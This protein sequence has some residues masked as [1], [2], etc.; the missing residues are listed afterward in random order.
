MT[1]KQLWVANIIIEAGLQYRVSLTNSIP[2]RA[3]TLRYF[4][5][6]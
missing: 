1:L 6:A 2:V 4:V 5:P 3:L